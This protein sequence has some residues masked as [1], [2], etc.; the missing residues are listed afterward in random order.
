MEKDR[1]QLGDAL[2]VPAGP[3][4]GA[5]P[6]GS[7]RRLCHQSFPVHRSVLRLAE[8]LL[9]LGQHPANHFQP[10]LENPG[11]SPAV[12]DGGDHGQ[13]PSQDPPQHQSRQGVK[14]HLTP[15]AHKQHIHKPRQEKQPL[16]YGKKPHH[17]PGGEDGGHGHRG[18]P[19]QIQGKSR[20]S[21]CGESTCNH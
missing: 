19:G 16:F 12:G 7:F 1:R 11:L 14:V 5:A 18:N 10:H 13:E 6:A 8:K 15:K 21:R 17:I 3:G 2:T 4:A 20:Q 9:R